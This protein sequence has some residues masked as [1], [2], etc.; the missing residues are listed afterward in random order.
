MQIAS[1]KG[2]TRR[3]N[4]KTRKRFSYYLIFYRKKSITVPKREFMVLKPEQVL[5]LKQLGQQYLMKGKN[6]RRHHTTAA[7]RK[8]HRRY[9]PR[10]RHGCT[11][12]LRE[13]LEKQLNMTAVM[14]PNNALSRR[15][16]KIS[17]G[18]PKLSRLP[19]NPQ[20]DFEALEML[21]NVQIT[22]TLSGANAGDFLASQILQTGAALHCFLTED[23]FIIHEVDQELSLLRHDTTGHYIRTCVVGD[24]E[25]VGARRINYGVTNDAEPD[26]HSDKLHVWTETWGRSW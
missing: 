26:K 22:V 7:R 13:K 2:K 17:P 10:W 21:V 6:D 25:L 11:E 14:S 19:V 24:A 1:T 4:R 9:R 16:V 5:V 3:K 20:R 15:S 23:L 8:R 18:V 12:K